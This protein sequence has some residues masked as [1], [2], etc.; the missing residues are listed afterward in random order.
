MLPGSS[1]TGRLV[2]FTPLRCETKKKNGLIQNKLLLKQKIKEISE[3]GT[4]WLEPMREFINQAARAAKI[5]RAK[6]N[7]EELSSF[8]RNIGSNFILA[9]R[10]LVADLK[11][12]FELVKTRGG[13]SADATDSDAHSLSERV[14][15]VPST[16]LR[17]NFSSQYFYISSA[18]RK[19]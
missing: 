12:P 7:C 4:E 14:R 15:G 18:S 3:N 9:D 17:V 5:A 10:R 1:K 6:N 11:K 2:K 16:T 8:A 13:G 19:W